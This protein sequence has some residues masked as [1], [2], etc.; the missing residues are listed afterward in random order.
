MQSPKQNCETPIVNNWGHYN[1]KKLKSKIHSKLR[2][3][4]RNP[5]F[6][7]KENYYKRKLELLEEEHAKKMVLLDLEIQLKQ[8]QL[9]Q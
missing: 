9:S 6:Y 2:P 5:A 8:K 4:V 3:T 7:N 1:S